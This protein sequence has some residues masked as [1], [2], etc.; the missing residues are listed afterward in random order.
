MVFA[1]LPSFYSW[2]K[3]GLPCCRA[4][5]VGHFWPNQLA[6]FR[7]FR[8]ALL[9]IIN[10]SAP[11]LASTTTLRFARIFFRHLRPLS[12]ALLASLLLA[13]CASSQ[14]STQKTAELDE[15]LDE[16]RTQYAYQTQS[17]PLGSYLANRGLTDRGFS[18]MRE[19]LGKGNHSMVSEALNLLGVKYTF[20]G[21]DP[22]NGF[23]CSGLVG[24]VAE[25][26]LGLK[27]PRSS[28]ELAKMGNSINK[29][30][31][32]QGDLVFFN[33]RGAR[34]S[35]VGIYI[36]N[37]KFVHAPRTGAVVRVEDMGVSY[38][39][40]RFTGAR[41]LDVNDSYLARR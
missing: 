3:F 23:D 40:Q 7:P 35:H 39:A 10:N 22:A 31:L 29:N 12:G 25:Q 33:T 34:F 36:G 13:G 27:L 9:E 28:A 37:N 30:E 15:L 2:V 24:Y 18:H 5:S 38:W 4:Q 16:L 17:D 32:R 26:S 1:T 19:D 14:N 41:R 20:G 11:M 21:E 8:W 6:V